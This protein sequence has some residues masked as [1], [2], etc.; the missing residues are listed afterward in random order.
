MGTKSELKPEVTRSVDL[1]VCRIIFH[2]HVMQLSP[3]VR[4]YLLSANKMMTVSQSYGKQACSSSSDSSISRRGC[5]Q[6]FTMLRTRE[7]Q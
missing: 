4:H 3:V 1:F 6:G 5:D 7:L 2:T